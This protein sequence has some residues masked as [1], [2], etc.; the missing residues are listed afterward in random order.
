M[1]INATQYKIKIYQRKR[2][3]ERVQG[4]AQ[5]TGASLL[6][7]KAELGFFNPEKRWLEGDFIT[8]ILVI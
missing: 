2:D 1:K 7:Q 5:G 4:G 8:Q 6:A 3:L